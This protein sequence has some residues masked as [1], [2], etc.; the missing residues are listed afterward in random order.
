MVTTKDF[1]QDVCKYA[2]STG[3]FEKIRVVATSK[4]A[5]VETF[6]NKGMVFKGKIAGGV[7]DLEGEFG[8]SN[9]DLLRHLTS[10]SEYNNKETTLEAVYDTRD[11]DKDP[12][13]F[14][15]KNKSNSFMTYRLMQKKLIPNQPKFNEPKW[16]V[17]IKPSKASV[18][19]F[20]WVAAGLN[21]YEQYFTPKV[22]DGN[23]K[24]FIGEENAASQRG[25]IVFASDLADDFDCKMRWKISEIMT[26]LKLG[27]T[28]DCQMSI[29]TKGG[30]RVSLTTGIGTYNYM[31]PASPV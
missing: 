16:D 2:V 9:L 25:G 24:F 11:G 12:S 31:F 27:D 6:V 8:L 17:I 15:Y 1:M 5:I 21:T 30:I 7:A 18:Q 4:D 22:I 10:D 28:A 20:A 14:N 13:E 3:F 19:Q 23:L 29:S 26:V